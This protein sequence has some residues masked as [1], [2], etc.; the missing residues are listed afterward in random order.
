MSK[1]A[2]HHHHHTPPPAYE[3]EMVGLIGLRRMLGVDWVWQGWQLGSTDDGDFL[4]QT[5]GGFTAFL[6]YHI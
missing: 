6:A 2:P 4:K 1:S 5:P 3:T